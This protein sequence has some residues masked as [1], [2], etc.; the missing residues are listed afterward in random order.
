VDSGDF[1]YFADCLTGPG[2]TPD[3][4]TGVVCSVVCTQ[5]FDF[6]GDGDVDL[7]DYAD[8]QFFF[9]SP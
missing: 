4:S 6:D 3:P 1:R 8:F 2:Q 5:V 7:N 9:A